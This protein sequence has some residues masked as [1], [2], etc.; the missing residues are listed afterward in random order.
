[1]PDFD[2]SKFTKV[3]DDLGVVF[4]YAIVCKAEGEDYY[5]LHGDHIPQDAM[6]KA[7]LEFMLESRDGKVMHVGDVAG[8]VPFAWPETEE[9]ADQF[10]VVTKTFG[11]KIGWAPHDAADLAKFKDGTFTGFSIGGEYGDV[12]ELPD[13]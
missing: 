10:G 8:T 11:L 1:M 5:D 4:G 12:E 2:T 9:V 13:E 7:A 3:D 6:M